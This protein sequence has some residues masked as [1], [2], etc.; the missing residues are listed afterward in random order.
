M[1]IN[2]HIQGAAKVGLTFT[3]FIL[4]AG[5]IISVQRGM[6]RCVSMLKHQRHQKQLYSRHSISISSC[7]LYLPLS[8]QQP[9]CPPSTHLWPPPFNFSWQLNLQHPSAWISHLLSNMSKPSQSHL[10]CPS[11]AFIPNPVYPFN[12]WQKSW[13]LQL[14]LFQVHT[15][16]LFVS[17]KNSKPYNIAGLTNINWLCHSCWF[18]SVTNHSWHSS[19]PTPFSLR[20]P[21]HLSRRHHLTLNSWP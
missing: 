17:A 5:P 9:A 21:L 2:P 10:C 7:P 15:H 3:R 1:K 4:A 19:A 16:F 12:F 8:C 13:H 18:P 14:Q 11:N 20:T 6:Q